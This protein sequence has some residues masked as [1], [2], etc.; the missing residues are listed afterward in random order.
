MK[1]AY[2]AP[3]LT[4]RG[5]IEA[6]TQAGWFPP[7]GYPGGKPKPHCRHRFDACS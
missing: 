3:K 1:K 5:T 6:I 7:A 4:V 2:A